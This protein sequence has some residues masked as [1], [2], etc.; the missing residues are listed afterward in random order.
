MNVLAIDGA[1]GAFSAAI[2]RDDRI[3]ASQSEPGAVALEHGLSVIADVLD[4]GGMTAEQI[5][6]LAVGIGPGGFTGLRIAIS[7]AKSL[8]AVWRVPL[9]PVE[10]FDLLELG[11]R[12][13]SVLA[14]VVGRPGVISARYRAGREMRRASGRIP[15]VLGELFPASQPQRSRRAEPIDVVG[16]PEDVL[17]ALAERAII[18]RP[19]EPAIMPAAAAAAMAESQR[20]APKSL[21]EVRADYGELPAARMPTF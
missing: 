17:H 3:V 14:V 5:D 8:A 19:A 9:V 1:L 4:R 6:R 20:A 11:G 12:F 21:H 15:D 16:A 2:A 13:D 7:Y 18:V 10:S